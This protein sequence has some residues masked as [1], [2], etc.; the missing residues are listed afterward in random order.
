MSFA[1]I[2]NYA[3]SGLP[4]LWVV[5]GIFIIWLI[6]EL[7]ATLRRTRKDVKAFAS[8]AEPVLKHADEAAAALKPAIDNI[9]AVAAELENSAAAL[10]PAIENI[11]SVAANLEEITESLKPAAA[12]IQPLVDRVALTVDA[13]NLELMRVDQ[14]LENVGEITA[15][16]TSATAAVDTVTNAPMKLVSKASSSVRGVIKGKSVSDETAAMAKERA[17]GSGSGSRSVISR[18]AHS[19]SGSDEPEE[20]AEETE[21]PEEKPQTPKP[22]TRFDHFTYPSD[23]E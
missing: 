1:E 22:G 8:Q 21:T 18:L 9:G 13:A 17:E 5:I 10:T 14:I 12:D 16:L 11:G 20:P 23:S 6:A 4:I 7:V 19:V 3:Q 2:A 15:S